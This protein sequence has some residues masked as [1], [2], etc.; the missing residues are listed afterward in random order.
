MSA[1]AK[2]RWR[3]VDYL[4]A[5]AVGGANS[6]CS[7]CAFYIPRGS[8]PKVEYNLCCTEGWPDNPDNANNDTIFI[9]DTPEAIAEY[10]AKKLGAADEV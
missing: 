5:R 1:N 7:G 4:R 9:E 8:C 10:V 6:N 2:F 3:G